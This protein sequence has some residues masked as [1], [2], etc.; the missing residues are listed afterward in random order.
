VKRVRNISGTADNPPCPCGSWLDHWKNYTGFDNPA[1]AVG[2]CEKRANVGGHVLKA[3]GD[4]TQYIIPLCY[5]HNNKRDGVLEIMDLVMHVKATA[6]D[7]CG[8]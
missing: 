4:M 6:R 7:K 1:C 5:E 8:Q 2:G 3:G